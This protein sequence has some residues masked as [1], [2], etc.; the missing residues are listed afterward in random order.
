MLKVDVLAGQDE[1]E[2]KTEAGNE[3]PKNMPTHEQ[4]KHFGTV[5][6]NQIGYPITKEKS[7][8][9]VVLLSSGRKPDRIVKQD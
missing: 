4:I 5:L 8:S 9:R 2:N 7:D 6:G 3:N 1:T